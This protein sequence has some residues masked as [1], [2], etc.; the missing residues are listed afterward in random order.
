M[1]SFNYI[2]TKLIDCDACNKTCATLNIIKPVIICLDSSL[3]ESGAPYIEGNIVLSHSWLNS[4]GLTEYSYG[5]TYD[6]SQLADPNTILT[7]CDISGILCKGCLSSYVEYLISQ[8]TT[9]LHTDDTITVDIAGDGTSTNP[10]EATINISADAGNALT[11]NSDGLYVNVSPSFGWALA[12]N[13]GTDPLINFVGTT[14]A[15]DLELRVNSIKGIRLVQAPSALKA[16]TFLNGYT[17]NTITGSTDCSIFSGGEDSD[18]NSIGTSTYSN[19]FAGTANDIADSDFADIVSGSGNSILLSDNSLIVTGVNNSINIADT[20]AEVSNSIVNGQYCNIQYSDL[21]LALKTGYSAIISGYTSTILNN[22]YSFIGTGYAN[23]IDAS[24]TYYCSGNSYNAIVNGESNTIYNSEGSFIGSGYAHHCKFGM[25][26]FIGSGLSNKIGPASISTSITDI[27]INNNA[28]AGGRYNAI[29]T[30]TYTID[31]S[32]MSHSFIGGGYNNEIETAYSV[33]GGGTLNVIKPSAAANVTQGRYATI[34][35]G[36]TNTIEGTYGTIAGGFTNSIIETIATSSSASFVGGG[37]TDSITN[38]YLSG[39]CSGYYNRITVPS[40]TAS[41][42]AG[43]YN[44]IAGGSHN[45]IIDNRTGA[46]DPLTY[47]TIAG[48]YGGTIQNTYNS[49]IVGGGVNT[50]LNANYCSILGGYSNKLNPSTRASYSSILGG[51]KVSVIGD[52]SIAGGLG[53]LCN[54]STFAYQGSVESAYSCLDSWTNLVDIS[55]VNDIAYFGDVDI[56]LGNINN[57]AKRVK[58]YEPYDAAS[59]AKPVQPLSQNYSSIQAQAQA[60]NIE[61]VLPASA[62]NAGQQL[63]ID[64]VVGNVVTLKWA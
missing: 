39:I 42:Q 15:Q 45:L 9:D 12:G 3:T 17:G 38:S 26:N 11:V 18:I 62:G 48:G 46:R 47:N 24:S 14:D 30:N 20:I 10:L 8:V 16:V 31:T 28:I 5:I 57:T 63:T 23:T 1:K 58:F 64:T 60:A 35:G 29:G 34:G 2:T 37:Q 61:Y 59:L 51:G 53:V 7:S 44:V 22:G 33:I 6:E 40:I 50:V 25:F 21:G 32:E 41:T 55:A 56:C 36:H 52:Y 4:C 49:A 54:R 19:I 13:A 43:R 27:T